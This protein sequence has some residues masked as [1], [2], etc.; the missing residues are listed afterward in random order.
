MLLVKKSEFAPLHLR[1]FVVEKDWKVG[2]I[3]R[4]SSLPSLNSIRDIF[5]T[6][7]FFAHN[8]IAFEVTMIHILQLKSL[9]EKIEERSK[10]LNSANSRR[11]ARAE[12]DI[13]KFKQ[14]IANYYTPF[15]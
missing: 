3:D 10:Y 6:S 1:M 7:Y 4:S 2:H 8:K 13:E 15:Q 14:E 5:I 12:A 11:R 9:R